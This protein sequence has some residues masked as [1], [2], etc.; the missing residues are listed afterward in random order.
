MQVRDHAQTAVFYW[1]IISVLMYERSMLSRKAIA[2]EHPLGC[3]VACVASRCAISYKEAHKF[4]KDEAHAWTRGYYCS[5]VAWALAQAGLKYRFE[6]FDSEKH[7]AYVMREGTLV[8]VER[9]SKHP[10]GHYLLRTS[11][12]WMNP[13]SNFPQMI[14]VTANFETDLRGEVEYIIYEC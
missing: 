10:S 7:E 8:F 9:S 6:P 11:S 2:Q 1:K 13:W 14:Q 3:S 4:F 5:E 12:G